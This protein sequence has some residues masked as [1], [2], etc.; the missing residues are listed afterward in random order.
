ML[1]Y[2]LE[3]YIFN[4]FLFFL[5]FLDYFILFFSSFSPSFSS[6]FIHSLF[7]HFKSF[8]FRTPRCVLIFIQALHSGALHVPLVPGVAW[9]E[10][11]QSAVGLRWGFPFCRSEQAGSS[12]SLCR[13]VIS[14]LKTQTPQ[15]SLLTP[16]L[17]CTKTLTALLHTSHKGRLQALVLEQE[18]AAVLR[19]TPSYVMHVHISNSADSVKHPFLYSDFRRSHQEEI[20]FLRGGYGFLNKYI[21]C[22]RIMELPCFIFLFYSFCTF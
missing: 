14:F 2:T 10:R 7:V 13:V 11:H 4:S 18:N 5:L 3:M 19:N 22:R 1:K 16:I 20:S 9:L 8:S 6:S 15:Q 12:K 21:R 17:S